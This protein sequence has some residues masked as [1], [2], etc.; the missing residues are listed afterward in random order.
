MPQALLGAICRAPA[1]SL[2]DPAATSES[3]TQGVEHPGKDAARGPLVAA[4]DI[5]DSKPTEG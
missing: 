2:P 5:M 1:H 4:V 3:C